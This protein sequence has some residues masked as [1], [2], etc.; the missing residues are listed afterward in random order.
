MN[1]NNKTNSDLKA[2]TRMRQ[3]AHATMSDEEMMDYL[4]Q[5]ELD[6]LGVLYSRYDSMVKRA[7]RRF[8][9]KLSFEE[10]EELSQDTFLVLSDTAARFPRNVKVKTWLYGIA[11]KT[12][13]NARRTWYLH[14]K[15]LHKNKQLAPGMAAKSNTSP[16]HRTEIKQAVVQALSKLPD[17]QR[18]V[19]VLHAVEG[20]S[21]EE[22]SA[23]L[24]I[25]PKTVWTRLHRARRTVQK[26]LEKHSKKELPN[27]GKAVLWQRDI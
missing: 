20:F 16:A 10:V 17:G 2:L 8:A 24:G 25:K 15:L 5:G 18:E 23:I 27:A 12:A 14:R 19:L 26:Q 3:A 7:I 21:G 1:D 9:P 4:A 6:W 13:K 22:I 11:V